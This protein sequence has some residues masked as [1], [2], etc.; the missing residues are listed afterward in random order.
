MK[1]NLIKLFGGDLLGDARAGTK[2]WVV[3]EFRETGGKAFEK[4]FA[5]FTHCAAHC[6]AHRA[7]LLGNGIN[8][9][10]YPS[11]PSWMNFKC[12]FL[13]PVLWLASFSKSWSTSPCNR[14]H[15]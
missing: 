6:A 2:R 9:G 15:R 5:R 11:N 13:V 4:Y 8:Q 12:A 7:L 3:A 1:D 14:V 10:K